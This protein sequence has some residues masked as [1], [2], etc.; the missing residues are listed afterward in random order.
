MTGCSSEIDDSLAM[1]EIE[2]GEVPVEESSL[3]TVGGNCCE[4]VIN[5]E[6]KCIIIL[7]SLYKEE[8]DRI[9]PLPDMDR[10]ASQEN[11]SCLLKQSV[12]DLLAP[13]TDML[14]QL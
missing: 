3:R 14:H 4:Q 2:S 8:Q 11:G 12:S 13:Q 9:R 10:P 6:S 1:R 5:D 7:H